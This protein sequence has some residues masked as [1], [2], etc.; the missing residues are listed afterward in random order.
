MKATEA[1]ARWALAAVLALGGATG[2]SATGRKAAGQDGPL[3][4]GYAG[5]PE[6]FGPATGSAPNRAG[7]VAVKGGTF[8]LGSRDGYPEEGEPQRKRVRDF[9]IDRHEVTNAQFAAFVKATGYVTRAER[10]LDAWA[11][12]GVP[13]ERLVPS[14]VVFVPPTQPTAAYGWW[15]LIP[16]ADWRHPRG[17]GSDIEGLEN[18]P[19]VHVAFEDAQAYARWLGRELPTEAQWEYAARGGLEGATYPWGNTP[20]LRGRAM[21]N[22]WQGRFPFED[23][24][25][26]GHAGTAPVGCFEPNGFGLVDVVGNAWEWTRDPWRDR[27]GQDGSDNPMEVKLNA[28]DGPRGTQP[29]VIKGGSFLCAPDFCVRYRPSS[30]QP[31]DPLLATQHLGFRTVLNTR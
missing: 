19:V 12:P 13:R 7:L 24:A 22:S 5:L 17:P 26:D 6:G 2:A 10:P 1:A 27:H 9:W 20:E 4:R 8:T 3:C 30:R 11:Y 25:A 28:A 15:K 21:A 23:D 14:S 16:G 31:Q 29:R 18:H